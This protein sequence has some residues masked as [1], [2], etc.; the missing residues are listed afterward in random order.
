MARATFHQAE[1]ERVLRAARKTNCVVQI[2]MK[3]LV[4]TITPAPEGSSIGA[5]LRSLSY[6]QD[7]KENWD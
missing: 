4:M 7:G 6:A 3:T 5:D 2:D 1:I